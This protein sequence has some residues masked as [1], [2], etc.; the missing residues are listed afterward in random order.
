M[1]KVTSRDVAA[2]AG[3]S[4]NTVSLVARDSPRIRPETKLRVRAAME[5]LGYHRNALAAA[6]RSSTTKALLFAAR[7]QVIHHHVTSELLAGAIEAA[8]AHGYS[9]L[10]SAVGARGTEAAAD[11]YHGRWVGGAVVFATCSDD[12][13]VAGLS[14]A[15]CPTV[16]LVQPS[17]VADVVRA[18]DFGGGRAAALHLLARGRRPVGVVAAPSERSALG[19]DRVAG[20]QDAA[21]EVPLYVQIA[22]DWT[23]EAGRQAAQALL[24]QRP[25]PA[26]IFAVSDRLA[27]GVLAAAAAAGLNV[28]GDLAVVGFDNTEWSRYCTPPLTTVDFP[29]RAVGRLGVER[30]LAPADSPRVGP[31]PTELIIRESA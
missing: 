22:A 17:D 18:D 7:E 1:A 2:A 11:L 19:R 5:R 26:G 28:P 29:L 9:L 13:I 27:Y 24:L 15:G 3:V 10:V 21:G 23:V 8:S 30:L 4:Q 14:A 20:A 31:V 6:L 16:S 12:P 25:R